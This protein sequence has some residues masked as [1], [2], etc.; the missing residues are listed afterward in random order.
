MSGES[1]SFPIHFRVISEEKKELL[2]V[3]V[4]VGVKVKVRLELG[5]RL[6]LA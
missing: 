2:W 4:R 1:L 3:R 6:W 5:L